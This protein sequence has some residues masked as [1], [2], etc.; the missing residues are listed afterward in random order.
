[1]RLSRRTSSEDN[2]LSDVIGGIGCAD[3][4]GARVERNHLERVFTLVQMTSAAEARIL[5][6]RITPHP[7]GG[8]MTLRDSPRARIAGNLAPEGGFGM[9]ID[10]GEQTEIEQNVAAGRATVSLWFSDRSRVVRNVL[11]RGKISGGTGG[12]VQIHGS[13]DERNIGVYVVSEY[14]SLAPPTTPSGNAGRSIIEDN[15]ILSSVWGI[16]LFGA[17]DHLV[18]RNRIAGAELGIGI[19][20][21]IDPANGVAAPA[22]RNLIESNTITGGLLGIVTRRTSGGRFRD[23]EVVDAWI[24]VHD[25]PTDPFSSD[26]NAY[27]AN[28]VAR[29]GAFGFLIFGSSP[30]LERNEITGNGADRTLPSDAEPWLRLLGDNRG[31]LAFAPFAGDDFVLDDGKPDDDFSASPVI[32]GSSAKNL[33]ADN[34]GIDIYALDTSAANAPILD[35]DNHF[36]G[37]GSTRVVQEWFGLVRVVDSSGAPVEEAEVTV[38]DARGDV[39][40]V[41]TSGQ[42][43]IAPDTADPLRTQGRTPLDDGGPVP[44]WPR[45]SQYLVD[46]RGR[47]KPLTP[48]V[49]D[50]RAGGRTGCRVVGW[51]GRYQIAVVRLGDSCEPAMVRGMAPVRR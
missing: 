42:D 18:A 30:L 9:L 4:E 23:N 46:E 31:G 44:T 19:Y 51:H 22:D 16:L 29:N 37:K 27:H 8:G 26:P 48:H 21:L 5:D 39:V 25:G 2:I 1:M 28:R 15:V 3:C 7:L 13:S 17:S 12:S 10:R 43:G 34:T 14:L 50:A 11:E 36:K 33:F 40:A 24:G 6:N 49:I 35:R 47:R 20:A 32:G 41:M 45:L 38:R